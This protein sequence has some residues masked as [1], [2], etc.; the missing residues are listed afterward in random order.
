MEPLELRSTNSVN[1]IDLTKS[2]SRMD[3]GFIQMLGNGGALVAAGAY[4]GDANGV[5]PGELNYKLLLFEYYLV[6]TYLTFE[7][8]YRGVDCCYILF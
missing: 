3:V 8:Q 4:A 5:E 1:C 2:L 6:P 7:V